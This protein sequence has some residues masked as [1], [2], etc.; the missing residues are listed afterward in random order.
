MYKAM[1]NILFIS[2]VL[3]FAS[4]CS[5][6]SNNTAS[7]V[8]PALNINLLLKKVNDEVVSASSVQLQTNK[9]VLLLSFSEKIDRSTVAN[10]V[11]WNLVTTSSN[12]PVSI[13]FANGDSAL[14]IQ[15]LSPLA[16]LL[17]TSP[18]QKLNCCNCCTMVFSSSV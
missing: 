7:P 6:S 18:R 16:F 10:A 14:I 13:T 12:V 8:T 4:S 1:L 17:Q 11:T 2:A 5:K 3:L 9:A 15:P